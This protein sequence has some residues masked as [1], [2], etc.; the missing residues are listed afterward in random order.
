MYLNKIVANST[1][2]IVS[3][4]L[5]YIIL[6]YGLDLAIFITEDQT[7]FNDYLKKHFIK[8]FFYEMIRIGIYI[9]ITE[10]IINYFNILSNA[11][12]IL[13]LY[14]VTIILSGLHLLFINYS[15]NTHFFLSKW[16]KNVGWKD[17]IYEI[18]LIS[19]VYHVYKLIVRK[20]V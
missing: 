19:L 14:T 5:C 18:F 4:I 9:F 8:T 12:K 15:K 16:V 6:D 3:F 10:K 17:I 1:A 7:M 11:E 20:L 2:F 13:I